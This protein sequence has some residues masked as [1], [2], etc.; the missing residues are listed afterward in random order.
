MKVNP[1][2]L[3][4]LD[5]FGHS[6]ILEHNAIA[7]ARTPNWDNLK[8]NFPHSLINASENFVGLPKGQMGNS[9]VGHLSIGAGRIIHQDLER[10][11][12][13]IMTGDF[14]SN[15]ILKNDFDRIGIEKNNLHIFGLL[16]DGGVHSHISHFEALIK[17]ANQ[18]KIKKVFI[19]AFLDGRD[20]PPK[21]AM[22]YIK[23]IGT[24]WNIDISGN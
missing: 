16:S 22:K 2:I 15:K 18:S 13:S 7:L 24:D 23:Y 3:I 8:K 1:V 5:G 20:T 17:L 4:I 19:H 21:S 9:E 11:N 14:F 12:K 6:E 10:I